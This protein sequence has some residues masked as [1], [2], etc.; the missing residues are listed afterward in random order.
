MGECERE[1]NYRIFL[2]IFI[3]SGKYSGDVVLGF[4]KCA[5]ECSENVIKGWIIKRESIE[6]YGFI[7]TYCE[8]Y[9]CIDHYDI[10]LSENNEILCC[11]CNEK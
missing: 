7:C 1:R 3:F 5:E 10:Y 9:Y 4:T 11:Y 2:Y 6:N 8:S